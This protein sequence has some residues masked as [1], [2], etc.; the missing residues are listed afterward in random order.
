MFVGHLAVAFGAKAA[1]PRAPLSGLIA[2]SFGLDLIWPI[3]VL[4][5]VEIVRI[6]PGITAFT[7]LDFEHYPW[8]HSLAMS[9]VWGALAG[10]LAL[11]VL[12]SVRV[13]A[14]I[15]AVVVS[16]WVLDL[17][18]HRPDLPILLAGPKVGLGLWNSIPG[19]LIFEGA[20]FAAGVALYVRSAKPRDAV[21]RWA[22]WGLVAFTTV[23]WASQPW[24]PPP[25]SVTAV[26]A[27]ALA[28]W[29]F[30]FWGLWIERH[31]SSTAS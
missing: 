15:G 13:A 5:G 20:L 6:A 3:C 17:A 4:A 26:A 14:V 1:T 18:T 11:V 28:A 23:I 2:A 21:G 29:V 16:H 31:R 10:V 19:T 22:L 24:S 30:P 25:P 12:K 27:V 7:P 8:S 9:V